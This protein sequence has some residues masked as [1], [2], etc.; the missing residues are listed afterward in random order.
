M[1]RRRARG[2]TLVEM[3]VALAIGMVMSVAVLAVMGTFEMQRRRLQSGADLDQTGNIAMFQLDRWVRSAGSG[4]AQG[5]ADGS[6]GRPKGMSYV[7]G[8]ELFAAKGGQQLLPMASP[9]PAPFAAVTPG[10]TGSTGVFRLAP[11][12]ILPGQT[13]PGASG[14][15]SDVLVLM[16]SGSTGAQVPAS[17]GAA[18]TAS[19][20]PVSA[21]VAVAAGDLLLVAD[22]Q[23]SSSG[24]QSPCMVSQVD[25]SFAGAGTTTPVPPLPLGG[26]WYAATVQGR[27]LTDY[28]STGTAFDLGN[29]QARSGPSFQ[30][31]G[32]GDDDTLYSYDLLG[33]SSS[34]L[35][36]RADGVFELH[37]LYGVD[38]DGD[39]KLDAWVSPA[40]GNYA[41][42]VL[43]DGSAN[44]AALLKSIKAVRIGLILRTSSPERD[45][46]DAAGTLTLFADLGPALAYTRTLKSAEQHYRY[47]TIEATVPLRNNAF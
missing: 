22:S 16:S 36:A 20:L 32:V 41:P 28:S 18:A 42:E 34:A 46:V 44:A 37:A 26:A 30:V 13:V 47:R 19:T 5:V 8:C 39:G 33:V 21:A 43:L 17:L 24:G 4:L 45:P 12:V 23:P 3:M 10:G 7:Y 2:L 6:T 40:G 9:M 27:S 11:V 25:A 15:K 31:V 35:Q 38:T 14:S 1:M 29:P